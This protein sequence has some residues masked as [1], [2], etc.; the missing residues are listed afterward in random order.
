[1]LFGFEREEMFK[2]GSQKKGG[3]KRRNKM[4]NLFCLNIST[5]YTYLILLK[6]ATT[7]F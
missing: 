6:F 2:R 7:T 4:T 5:E 3:K 1:M